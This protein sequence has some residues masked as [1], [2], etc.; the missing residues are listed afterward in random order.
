MATQTYVHSMTSILGADDKCSACGT[1]G[2]LAR[3][4]A[5]FTTKSDSPQGRGSPGDL[6]K[7]FIEDTRGEI[8]KEKQTL[9]KG[10]KI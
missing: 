5:M 7:E 10:H 9:K 2:S 3:E 1:Y 4:P 6:V 8:K